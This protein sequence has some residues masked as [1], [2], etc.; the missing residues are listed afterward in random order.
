VPGVGVVG[1]L[2]R[3]AGWVMLGYLVLKLGELA[4]AG[5]L[6]RLLILDRPG[7]LLWAEL[8][9]GAALPAALLLAPARRARSGLALL[10]AG[11]I[12]AGV[13]LNRFSATWFA[14]APPAGGEYAPHALE[15]VSTLGVLAGAVL[16]WAL[17]VRYLRFFE[18]D[19]VA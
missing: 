1:G 15:W 11:L 2:G 13:L 10:A 8:L 12:L 5:E 3:G 17:G 18:D 9:P 6:G 7:L 14:Q 4:V 19:A 16:V